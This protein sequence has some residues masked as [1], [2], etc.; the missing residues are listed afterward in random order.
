MKK[1]SL[2]LLMTIGCGGFEIAEGDL[3]GMVD[4]NMWTLKSG[5]TDPFLSGDDDYSVT[6]YGGDVE[7]ACGQSEPSSTGP[8]I[9]ASIPKAPGSY[10]LKLSLFDL[11][12]SRTV[13]VVPAPGENVILSEGVIEVEKVEGD[14]LHA[15]MFAKGGEGTYELSGHF[16]ANV[17]AN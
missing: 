17:C 2:A 13:T 14:V 7:V 15:A 9:L 11:D 8:I 16:R 1:L 5:V 10:E 3:S 4:G 6:L 12:G